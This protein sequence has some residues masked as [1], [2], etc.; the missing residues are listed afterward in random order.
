M[1]EYDPESLPS[2]N[3]Q[4]AELE[5]EPEPELA[6]RAEDIQELRAATDKDF[7]DVSIAEFNHME[8]RM[9]DMQS[10]ATAKDQELVAKDQELA[11]KDQE[12]AAKDQELEQLRAQ[13]ARLEGV[14][15]Q[16]GN[17]SH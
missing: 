7:V 15:P 1:C 3:A 11:A 5:P 17:T 10:E 9:E 4:Q 13:L 8:Q 6:S 16:R 12:L 14:P 2:K